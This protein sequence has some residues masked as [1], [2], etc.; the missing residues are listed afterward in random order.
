MKRQLQGIA[1]L[2]FGILLCIGSG[3]LNGT[4]FHGF[5]Y[6][7]FAAIGVVLGVAGLIFSFGKTKD[8][9]SE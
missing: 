6:I 1:L 5:S 9:S 4:I 7:P 3:E 2:L 8:K